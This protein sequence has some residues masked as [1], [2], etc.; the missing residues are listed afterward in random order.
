MALRKERLGFVGCGMMGEAMVKG[1]LRERLVEPGQIVASHPREDRRRELE[2]AYGIDTVAANADAVRGATTVVVA[3]KPQR[4]GEVL[5]DLAGQVPAGA[6]VM[7]IVAGATTAIF[8]RALGVE[9]VV[10]VMPNTPAQIGHGMSVW[11][12]TEAV[13]EAGRLRAR[14]ILSALGEEEM[15]EHEEEIDMATALSGTGPAY[16]FLFMEALIDAGVHLGFSRRVAARLVRQTVLGAAEYAVEAPEHVARMRNEVTSPG[17]TTA[18]A[19]YQLERGRLRTVL[20]DAVWAAYRRCLE[21]GGR[22][23]E[24]SGNGFS[25]P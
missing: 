12:A 25:G 6:T 4:L 13:D 3:V 1:L 8:S 20:S 17:G 24:R 15:V 2:A 21:L 11:T 18:D 10:R 14:T 23:L 5:Q 9:R 22:S 16:V 19:L 7:S